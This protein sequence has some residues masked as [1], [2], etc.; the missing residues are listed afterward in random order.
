[1]G[2]HTVEVVHASARP[3][4][5]L[6]AELADHERLSRVLGVPVR[7][8]RDGEGDPNGVGSVR[9]MGLGLLRLEETVTAIEPQRSIEYRITRGAG[10]VRNHR[11]RLEFA[12][13]GTGSRVTWT[14]DYDS[15]PIVGG[16]LQ[17]LLSRALE[18]GLGKLA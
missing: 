13:V 15:L 6:F 8:V 3:V 17:K 4:Q 7:R 9:R 5:E 16:A 1:M 10:P 12:S 2:H 11:G 14:I 18:R